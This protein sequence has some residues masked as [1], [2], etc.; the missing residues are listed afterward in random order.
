MIRTKVAW[1]W[2]IHCYNGN[3]HSIS[4]SRN[5]T[6]NTR[7]TSNIINH[8]RHIH[9]RTTKARTAESN[10]TIRQLARPEFDIMKTHCLESNMARVYHQRTFLADIQDAVRDLRPDL[11]MGSRPV[12]HQA[13]E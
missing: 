6:R 12:S 7:N 10:P 13:D 5:R 1:S 3:N 4:S 2:A 11:A 9:I 8:S